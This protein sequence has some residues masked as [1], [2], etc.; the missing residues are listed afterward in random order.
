MTVQ[1]IDEHFRVARK[2]HHCGMCNKAIKVGEQ[3][4]VSTNIYDDRIYDWRECIWCHRDRICALVHAWWADPD[5]G[6]GY[7]SANEWAEEVALGWPYWWAPRG[8]TGR[9]VSATERAAAR[10]WL[11]R[12]AGGEGE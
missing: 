1:T 7:D 6:V 3:H 10:A 5:E 9:R 12:V 11:A 8:R 4:H 2:V